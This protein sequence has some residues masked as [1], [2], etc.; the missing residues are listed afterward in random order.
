MFVGT[1]GGRMTTAFQARAT[2]GLWVCLDGVW[3]CVDPGPG[4]LAHARGRALGLDPGVLDAIVLTHKHLD[5]SGDVNAMI[6]AMTQGGTKKRGRVL[7]PRDAYDVDPVILHYVRSYPA[8]TEFLVPG[9]RYAIGGE[10]GPVLETPLQLKH[11]VETYGLRFVG[12]H[13]TVGVVACT[14]YLPEIETALRA[15]LLILNVVYREPRDEIHLALP[16]AR[17]LITAMRPRLAILTHFGLTML[18]GAPGSWPRRSRGDGGARPRR[19]R[20]LAAR[21]RRRVGV[22]GRRDLD[23]TSPGCRA[24]FEPTTPRSSQERGEVLATVHAVDDP[25]HPERLGRADV[26]VVVV[27]E[28][29]GLRREPEPCRRAPVDLEV[30]L[31]HTLLGRRDHRVEEV[32][33]P[34]LAEASP[35][36]LVGVREYGRAIARAGA[37]RPGGCWRGSGAGAAH[38]ASWSL[39]QGAAGPLLEQPVRVVPPRGEVALAPLDLA[40]GRRPVQGLEQGVAGQ[41]V[42]VLE[43]GGDVPPHVDQ[44]AAEV[45]DDSADA[46]FFRQGRF[47]R[48]VHDAVR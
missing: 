25:A 10:H 39:G 18:P 24:L 14:G 20:P 29:T 17:Q 30:R 48:R 31:R 36:A 37:A 28:D 27:H 41:A 32:M 8:S 2:G 45:E 21:S 3:V 5:H 42:G 13:F 47:G 7:A 9:G 19:P 43:A 11:P 38:Q 26:R 4:A 16:D 40:P 33:N 12:R 1:G 34:E 6:E 22:D 23:R 15:D 44:D 35:Q 46:R